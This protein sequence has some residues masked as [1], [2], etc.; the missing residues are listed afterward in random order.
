MS[1]R[2]GSILLG[3]TV[4]AVGAMA[5]AAYRFRGPLQP[6]LHGV[7]SF[8]SLKPRA[9]PRLVTAAA[10]GKHC[11]PSM[12]NMVPM[13][14]GCCIMAT[15]L[16]NTTPPLPIHTAGAPQTGLSVLP[17]RYPAVR[18]DPSITD[19]L[20]GVTVSDPYRWLEDPDAK[21][22]YACEIHA[23]MGGSTSVAM[24]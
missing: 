16:T 11:R 6:K 7:M 8:L 5:A 1:P 21:E 24:G 22:T 19:K 3:G 10:L 4:V 12:H 9:S 13:H 17:S 18:R 23:I 20:H 15:W 2:T 14:H